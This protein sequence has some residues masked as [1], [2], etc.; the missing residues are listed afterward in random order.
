MLKL[1]S[2][3]Q[4]STT[5]NQYAMQ[6]LKPKFAITLIFIMQETMLYNNK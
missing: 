3:P 1:F 2:L 4:E 5:H 6:A